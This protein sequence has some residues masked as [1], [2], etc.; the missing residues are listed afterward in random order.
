MT[1][2]CQGQL[3]QLIFFQVDIDYILT[4]DLYKLFAEMPATEIHG[5]S[6]LTLRG[7]LRSKVMS[8][9]EW[10]YMISYRCIIQTKFSRYLRKTVK[11]TFDL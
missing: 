11:V 6:S 1:F 4:F 7:H 10:S 8:P 5:T 2:D 9:N 3:G